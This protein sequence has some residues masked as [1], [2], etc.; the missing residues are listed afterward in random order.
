VKGLKL[1]TG[2]KHERVWRIGNLQKKTEG[3]G[4]TMILPSQKFEKKPGTEE[5]RKW[6][7]RKWKKIWSDWGTQMLQEEKNHKR[8]MRDDRGEKPY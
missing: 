3:E 1:D 8:Q 4:K 7:L 5:K 6:Q 2:T